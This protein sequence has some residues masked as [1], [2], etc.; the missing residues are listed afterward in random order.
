QEKIKRCQD[1]Q[2][3]NDK[4]LEGICTEISFLQVQY[5]ACLGKLAELH[6][7]EVF[8]ISEL[9]KKRSQ[10]SLKE[11]YYHTKE[12]RCSK[13]K[14]M[15]L[16]HQ[17]EKRN[18]EVQMEHLE[19]QM[20]QMEAKAAEIGICLDMNT[21]VAEL[22]LQDETEL[23]KQIAELREKLESLGEVNLMAPAE[24]RELDERYGF[25]KQQKE[26]LEEGKRKL[27]CIV[28]EMDSIA[29]RRFYKTYQDVG[30]QFAEI[31]S[32]LCE[33]GKAKLVLTDEKDILKTG[34][35]IVI[36]PKGKKPRHLSL[37]SGGEKALVGI[38]FLFALLKTHASP[39]YLLDEIDAFLDEANLSRFAEFLSEIG[40]EHQLILI[41]HRYPTMRV[42]D[43]LYGVTMEEPGVSKVVSVRLSD[44]EYLDEKRT[45][46]S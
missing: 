7:R 20:K 21:E 3:R 27:E 17:Q 26:D 10:L 31:Y 15:V 30:R 39:F 44:W 24:L 11:A 13:L 18:I 29:I 9:E 6:E 19:E 2:T 5:E 22:S 40:K 12:K 42:A 43:T 46:A 32:T 14:Q 34:V 41:T 16:Q 25:L 33:G 4:E 28:R 37:L 35:D 45:T 8:W 23:K 36:T 1:A 38:S